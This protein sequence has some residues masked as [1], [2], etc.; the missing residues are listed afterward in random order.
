M[1][2][3][4]LRPLLPHLLLQLQS[5]VP[6]TTLGIAAVPPI[7]KVNHRHPHTRKLLLEEYQQ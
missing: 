4:P 1:L 5:A 3:L 2:L 6:P 7:V